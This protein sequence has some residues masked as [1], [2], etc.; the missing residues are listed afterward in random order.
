MSKNQYTEI[1]FIWEESRQTQQTQVV[2]HGSA[3]KADPAGKNLGGAHN[4]KTSLKLQNIIY[5]NI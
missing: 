3:E 1:D 4:F 5:W 2:L